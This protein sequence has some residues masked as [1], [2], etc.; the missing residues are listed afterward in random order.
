MAIRNGRQLVEDNK[1]SPVAESIRFC[2]TFAGGGGI[3]PS[4]AVAR[5]MPN[6]EC[7][8]GKRIAAVAFLAAGCL[9]LAG[10]STTF[11]EPRPTGGAPTSAPTSTPV[12]SP[13]PTIRSGDPGFVPET[14]ASDECHEWVFTAVD[15]PEQVVG[16]ALQIPVDGGPQEYAMGVATL[17]A[18]GVPASY[19]VVS[20]DNPEFVAE[21]FCINLAYLY[22]INSVRRGDQTLFVGDIVNL[23][24]HTILTVGDQ[25][26]I[27]TAGP[28]PDP[29]PPQH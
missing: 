23:N 11:S 25:N 5:G 12:P 26:G 13:S 19:E 4:A 24:A 29:I 27:A 14:V 16:W 6:E 22:A 18:D 2:F 1:Q 28:A 17:D 7:T 8:M 10:C 15:D 3:A 20:G 21:R 9:S